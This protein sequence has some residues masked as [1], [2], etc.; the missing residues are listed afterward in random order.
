MCAYR[1]FAR[2]QAVI[3][4]AVCGILLLVPP[5]IAGV[6]DNRLEFSSDESKLD[7]EVKDTPRREVLK[8]LFSGSPIEIKW[9]SA[10]FAAHR[11]GG[12]FS[13]TRADVLRQLLVGTNFVIV[14]QDEDD[15]S[16][17]VRLIIVGPSNGEL[18]S[19]GLTALA[20]SIKP[21][22]QRDAF[23]PEAVEV[24]LM[25]PQAQ[26]SRLS[27]QL[28]DGGPAAPANAPVPDLLLARDAL[29]S[30]KV[31]NAD[32]TGVLVPPPEGAT[33]PTLVLQPGAEAS[34]LRSSSSQET[35]D[36]PII[37]QFVP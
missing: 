19:A 21:V 7:F 5:A 17:V 37:P 12:K 32:A 25:V 34:L 13:G 35:K 14:H 23:R 33:A 11:I 15:V 8:Q 20:A 29:L 3:R 22:N 16:R 24:G 10:S 1:A 26:P 27:P 36:V 2:V 18:S 31:S 28:T 9:I 6:G 4:A 30:G